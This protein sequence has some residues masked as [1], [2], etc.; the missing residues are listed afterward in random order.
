VLG[1]QGVDHED[2]RLMEDEKVSG[3]PHCIIHDLAVFVDN[4]QSNVS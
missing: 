2:H 3:G 4:S 1:T